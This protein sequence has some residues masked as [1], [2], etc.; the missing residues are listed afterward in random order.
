MASNTTIETEIESNDQI[1]SKSILQTPQNYIYV[2]EALCTRR[3]YQLGFMIFFGIFFGAFISSVYKM[4]AH[5]YI[6]DHSL[7]TTGSMS[8]LFNGLSRVIWGRAYD[9]YGFKRVYYFLLI[10]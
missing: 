2:T 5:Q 9:K 1:E 6:T 8:M 3:F 7:T 4:M 10:L